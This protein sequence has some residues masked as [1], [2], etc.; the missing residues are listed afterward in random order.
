MPHRREPQ[1]GS[2]RTHACAAMEGVGQ[3]SRPH[4]G[5]ERSLRNRLST[6]QQLLTSARRPHTGCTSPSDRSDV[7]GERGWEREEQCMHSTEAHRRGLRTPRLQ[8]LRYCNFGNR[9]PNLRKVHVRL[10]RRGGSVCS[11]RLARQ[12]VRFWGPPTRPWDL[13]GV[14]ATIYHSLPPSTTS[15]PGAWH[16]VTAFA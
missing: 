12:L 2:A 6:A 15:S 4:R 5:S 11:S 9:F 8:K 1:G 16:L 7:T 3:S 10:W 14:Y 13:I